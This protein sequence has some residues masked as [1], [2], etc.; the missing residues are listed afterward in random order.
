[1]EVAKSLLVASGLKSNVPIPIWRHPAVVT[2]FADSFIS[3]VR[4]DLEENVHVHS[5]EKEKKLGRASAKLDGKDL[6]DVSPPKLKNLKPA[7]KLLHRILNECIGDKN[8]MAAFSQNQSKAIQNLAS[9]VEDSIQLSST[10]AKLDAD[11]ANKF[12]EFLNNIVFKVVSMKKG[13][14]LILPGGWLQPDGGQTCVYVLYRSQDNFSFSISNTGDGLEYHPSSVQHFPVIKRKLSF[15][16]EGIPPERLQ[17]GSFWYLLFKIQL[18]PSE[19]HTA[20]VVYDSLL[21]YLNSTPL[22]GNEFA[23]DEDSFRPLP[24]SEDQSGFSTVAEACVIATRLRGFPR[25][26][27]VFVGIMRKWGLCKIIQ[28]ELDSTSAQL[29]PADNILIKIACKDLARTAAEEAQRTD[30]LMTNKQLVD[31]KTCA[32]NIERTLKKMLMDDPNY[33][34]FP[35]QL[36]EDSGA[37]W[38]AYRGFGPL[39]RDESI[40]K[41]AGGSGVPPIMRPIQFTLIKDEIKTLYDVAQ[42]LRHADHICTLLSYQTEHIKNSFCLR[43]SLIQHLFTQVIPLPLP[44]DHPRRDMDI[45]TSEIRY[46]TQLDILRS[47]LLVSRHFAASALSVRVTHSF[48]ATRILTMACMAAVADA[49]VRK[50]A[51]DVPS[52][53]SIHL[54][55]KAGGPSLPFGFDMGTFSK[56]S[57]RLM[58]NDAFY[59]VARTQVLDYFHAQRKMLQD[60]HLIFKWEHSME[61]GHMDTLLTQIC[62]E[63][64]FPMP[65]GELPK[66]LSGEKP[67]ICQF[68]PELV[69]YRDI[70]FTFKYFMTPFAEALPET[71]R[72]MPIEAQL[73]WKSKGPQLM[74]KGFGRVLNTIG[75]GRGNVDKEEEEKKKSI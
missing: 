55:G 1:M 17:D 23:K 40:E 60:D 57:T 73:R 38:A 39:R 44:L 50:T 34:L 42:A 59:A 27:E 74:V 36:P 18:F 24:M 43:I 68:F 6:E 33:T 70:I 25:G 7:F 3:K 49:C 11:D 19:F 52:L 47:L 45:W 62:Y 65:A 72:W 21:P 30:S 14:F 58:M 64:G 51:S 32:Y 8:I 75:E 54:D 29:S 67:E 26:L 13:D 37:T 28:A 35:P 31:L 16:I 12:L 63:I 48:D 61:L 9:A 10:V 4:D 66:Y 22:W 41:L 53:F 2:E 69:T 15:C 71:K 56:E 46:E 20:A 5:E